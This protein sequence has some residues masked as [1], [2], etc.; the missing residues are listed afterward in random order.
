[1]RSS[2]VQSIAMA[3]LVAGG[4]AGCSSAPQT[5]ELPPLPTMELPRGSDIA[6]VLA[7]A[8][9]LQTFRLPAGYRI[10]LVAAEPLVQEPVRMQ[11]DADGRMWVVEMRGYMPNIRDEGA[12]APIGRIAVLE[13]LN[14]DGRMD[15]RTVF[16]DSLVLPRSLQLLD[17][18]AALFSSPPN[19]WLARDTD[20]DLVADTRELMR[21]DYGN[22]GGNVE[23]N[24]NGFLWGLDNWL[25]S[26]EYPG[27]H[28]LVD[29]KLELRRT[30]SEGQWGISMD[31]YGRIYR[32]T[33]EDPLRVDLVSAHYATR[34]PNLTSIRGVYERLTPNVAVWPIHKTPAINR[35]YREQTMR[36]DSTLAHYTAANSPTIY[37]GDRLPAELRN[38]VFVAEPVANIV[39]RLEVRENAD[40]IPTAV[41]ID[42][43][44]E[45]LGST[46]ERFRPVYIT[47]APDGT[48]YVADMYRGIIQHLTY[49]TGYLNQQIVARGLEQPTGLGR[50]YRIVHETTEQA[51]KP[52]LGSRRPAQ[53]LEYL[54]HPNQWHRL[55]AQR[56]L[57]LRNDV[58]VAP[59]LRRLVKSAKDER[60]RLHA[61]WTLDGLKQAD[62]ATIQAAL[63]DASP[64]VRAAAVRI[65]EPW[66]AQPENP[67]RAAV[68][69]LVTDTA[70][71]VRRQVAA[72]LGELPMADREAALATVGSGHGDDP[73]V[74]DLIVTGVPGRELQ[75]L[76]RLLSAA[77]AQGASRAAVVRSLT[78][79]VA[80]GRNPA[81]VERLLALAT[82]AST[83]RAERLALLEALAPAQA[84]GPGGGGGGGF[85]GGGGGGGGVELAAQP[86]ALIALATSP[87][88]ALSARARRVEAAVSWPGKPRP[89]AAPVRPLNAE[90]QARFAAGQQ[91]Y[92]ATCAACHQ[93]NGEGMTG[94]SKPLAGSRWVQGNPTAVIRIVLHGKE[95]EMLMP[96]IGSTLSDDQVAAVLTYIRRSWGNQASAISPDEVQE[97]RGASMGRT[98]PWTE[99]ELAGR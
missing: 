22:P 83:P 63:A 12:D 40:G 68:M 74:A 61:I 77:P 26:S 14:N 67:V 92:V 99:D 23:H 2:L 88:T 16:V 91:Q 50:I 75:L 24:A 18:N 37:T 10:E 58:S 86:A 6:P 32:N 65:A 43:R 51:P 52:Q 81:N 62:P 3:A 5:V 78:L 70:P 60:T 71:P 80:R 7:P 48:L 96:P 47:N 25:H 97:V 36:A 54:S 42:E 90:E 57:V 15:K 87:D 69:A 35:G 66:I 73:I 79:A 44:T 21:N 41:R 95:G 53:L 11:W 72:S 45:F 30:P 56:L 17:G 94:L 84:G 27:Q 93:P 98:R 20:G 9:A 4:M 31:D 33:N 1:M 49:I 28:R 19:L 59:A 13:D 85:G 39:G 64:Y 82:N 89:A 8:Q 34:N 76:E 38:D 29:G 46:D 55:T